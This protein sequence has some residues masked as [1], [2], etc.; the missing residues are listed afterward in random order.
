MN[1]DRNHWGSWIDARS[2]LV[3]LTTKI[4]FASAV[5]CSVDCLARW[6]LLQLPPPQ[7]RKKFDVALVRVLKTDRMMLFNGY[8]NVDPRDAS[9]ID[10]AQN[11][12]FRAEVTRRRVVAVA[13]LL[14]TDQLRELARIGEA[15][16]K[17]EPAHAA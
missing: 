3:G 8:R 7:I 12:D 2:R 4:V 6:C 15:M 13:E 9:L 10:D 16:L 14:P 1:G 5:G 11:P 17:A